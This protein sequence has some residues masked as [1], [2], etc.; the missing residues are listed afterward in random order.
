V[1]LITPS[2]DELY[3]LASAAG[4]LG[5]AGKLLARLE[6]AC[7]ADP[8]DVA[9][10]DR[11]ALAQMA[12]LPSVGI[13]FAAHARFT[14]TIEA[15]GAVLALDPESWLARYSRA[16]LRAL[17]PSSYG[18]YA[19]R[20]SGE[21][22][23]ALDDLDQLIALQARCA[24]QPYFACTHA[25]AAVIDQLAGTPA[26]AGRPPLL[27]ALA[28]VPAI[29]VRLPALG[30][31][32]CEPLATLYAAAAGPERHAIGEVMAALHGDQP[33]VAELRGRPAPAVGRSR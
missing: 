28:A 16:R 26:P 20:I 12:V 32:L 19:V 24:P 17:T 22:A 10:A 29:P 1:R 33:V 13:E 23:G 5:R 9:A 11:F 7:R 15:L 8:R 6:D 2:D 25:L 4:K 3:G 27:E 21:L 18:A 30:A 14:D 31:V